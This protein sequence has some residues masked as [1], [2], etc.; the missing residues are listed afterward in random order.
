MMKDAMV[1]FHSDD[2]FLPVDVW[3][4]NMK[5]EPSAAHTQKY[6]RDP[7]TGKFAVALILIFDLNTV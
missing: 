2:N 3:G 1:D 5:Y 7:F 6:C 4:G